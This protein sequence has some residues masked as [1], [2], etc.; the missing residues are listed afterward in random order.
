VLLLVLILVLLL[1]APLMSAASNGHVETVMLLVEHGA[2]LDYSDPDDGKTAL[3]HAV[4]GNKADV[5]AVLLA[6]GADA[7]L[8]SK[9][10]ET[11]KEL[12]IKYKEDE[13]AAL[14]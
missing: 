3:M 10:G 1:I 13:I 9:D 5:V 12:A 8:Q 14:F 7:A 6:A 2:A 4:I 11:A